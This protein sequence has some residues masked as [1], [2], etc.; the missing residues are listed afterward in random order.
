MEDVPDQA[1]HAA[2]KV[3]PDS[4]SNQAGKSDDALADQLLALVEMFGKEKG[5]KVFNER[6]EDQRSCR[7]S[8]TQKRKLNT[9]GTQNLGPVAHPFGSPMRLLGQSSGEARASR[10]QVLVEDLADFGGRPI[11]PSMPAEPP[12]GFLG[13]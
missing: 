10:S 9:S 6:N 12:V 8:D 1:R 3:H 4:F 11:P 2:P 5:L 7:S 13:R